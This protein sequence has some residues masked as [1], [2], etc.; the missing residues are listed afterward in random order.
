M[1]LHDISPPLHPGIAVWPGDTPFTR[2]CLLAISAGDNI[3]LSTI[4]TTVHLGAHTD[5]PSHYVAAGAGID[6]RPLDLYLGPC[7]VV[8]VTVAPGARIYPSDLP[9]DLPDPLP[10][11]VLFCTGTFPDP[12]VWN[13]DFASLSPELIA[14]CHDR[15]ARLLGL[16]TPSIDPFDSKGLESHQAIAARDMAI[17]EGVVLTGVAPGMYEL[18]AL[19]LRLVGA[20]ASPVRAVLRSL[21]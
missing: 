12:D 4:H 11:R 16:D 13:A 9:Q 17:L 18:I 15:G 19:P 8:A 20:D 10:G 21:A 6:T 7:L 5:A 3:D 2:E 14:W 1:V